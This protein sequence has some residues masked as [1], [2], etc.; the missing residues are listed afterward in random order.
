[1]ALARYV[2]TVDVTVPGAF[3]PDVQAGAASATPLGVG[4]P[5]NFGTGGRAGWSGPGPVTFKRNQVLMID[6]A[7]TAGAA[8]QAAIGAG[9]L[10]AFVPGQD[11]RGGAGLSN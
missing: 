1:V 10:R 9:N 4:S 8:L 6:T 5:A 11:D 2:V 3:T 7:T